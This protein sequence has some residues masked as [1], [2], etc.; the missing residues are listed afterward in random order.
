MKLVDYITP[1]NSS[2]RKQKVAD[3]DQPKTVINCED[4]HKDVEKWEHDLHVVYV[5]AN[6]EMTKNKL[7]SL[8]HKYK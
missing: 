7:N 6:E 2:N 4:K 8:G 1:E 5:T 3:L